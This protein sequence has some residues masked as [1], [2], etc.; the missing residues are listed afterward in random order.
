MALLATFLIDHFE[1]FGVK[2]VW[3]H[4]KHCEMGRHQSR[5]PFF[6]KHPRHPLYFGFLIACWAA[7][8][9]RCEGSSLRLVS[10]GTSITALAF[11]ERDLSHHFGE[12]CRTY[13]ARVSMRIPL[14]PCKG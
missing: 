3:T 10:A 9:M 8:D 4:F 5:T 6:Y 14:P 12:Q 7:P 2:Q 1:L 13:M 11:E